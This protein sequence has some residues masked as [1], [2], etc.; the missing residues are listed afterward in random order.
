MR[1][2][3]GAGHILK[4]DRTLKRVYSSWMSRFVT[5]ALNSG[6]CSHFIFVSSVES[7]NLSAHSEAIRLA[8]A[9]DRRAIPQ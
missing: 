9:F 4:G 3:R 7:V 8:Q 1:E 2:P 6:H 5:G